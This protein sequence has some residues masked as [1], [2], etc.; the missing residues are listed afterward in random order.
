MIKISK[1]S[2]KDVLIEEWH[3]VDIPHYGKPIE[4]DEKKF[5][6]KAVENGELI[7][8]IDGKHESGVIYIASLITATK[9]RGRGVGTML[10]KKAEEFGKKLGAHRTWLITGKNWSENAFYKKLGFELIGNLPDFYFHKD[11]VIYTRLIK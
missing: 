7:G 4:W 1:A 11:F 8:T 3:K 6:F 2:A 9:V 5:R 10:I